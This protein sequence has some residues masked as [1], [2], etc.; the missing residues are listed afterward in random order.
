MRIDS[1]KISNFKG[2]KELEC[3][4]HPEFNLIVGENGTGKTALLDALSIAVA[5][6]FHGL[7]GVPQRLMQ[8]FEVRLV[9]FERR[10]VDEGGEEWISVNWEHQYPCIISVSGEV[11]GTPLSWSLG[12]ESVVDFKATEVSA[13]GDLA[14][15][16][17]EDVTSGGGNTLPLVSYYGTGRLGNY[18]PGQGKV[19]G[20]TG[21]A[22]KESRLDG[23]GK[24]VDASLAVT[25]VIRWIAREDWIT[26]QQ[27]GR[28]PAVYP[29][30]REAMI[31]CLEGARDI[32]FDAAFSEV[33][34]EFGDQI[35]HPF[36]NLSDG[37]RCVLA[38][39]GDIAMKAATLNPH[40]GRKV[41]EQTPGVVLIDELD[42]HLHPR[43]QRHV[44]EDLRRTFPK[45]QFFA[46]THSPQ[47]ISEVKPEHLLLLRREGHRIVPRRCGQTYGLDTNTVLEFIMG[48]DP[49]PKPASDAIR[50]VEDALDDGRLEDARRLL[51]EYR[52][53]V[54]GEIP[55][56][57]SLGATI[58]NLEALGDAADTEED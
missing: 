29:A 35:T 8:P 18:Q 56:T 9:P 32:R 50:K 33:I 4:F 47:L 51:D 16:A 7:R 11:S 27:R 5:G 14:R 37:Q 36:D 3:S 39:V 44:I 25:D 38:M 21:V 28:E 41:L 42:L 30:V 12:T 6:W 48:T 2:F 58:N 49:R 26:Y 53:L 40:L 22:R 1:L 24:G 10:N 17:Y 45:I 20:E 43:W 15:K 19:L 23:Y 34:V 31:R 46:A 52:E 55:D 13:I 54:H 57:V